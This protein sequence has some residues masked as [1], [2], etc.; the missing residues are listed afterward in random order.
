[1]AL[2]AVLQRAC[3]SAEFRAFAANES[4]PVTRW[5]RSLATLAHEQ[6]GGT[7][8]TPRASGA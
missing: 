4:S 7:L 1:M 8:L 3:V 5:L 6:Y 2:Y